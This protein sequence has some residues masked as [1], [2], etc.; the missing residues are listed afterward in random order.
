MANPVKATIGSEPY[1]TTIRVCND[2][3]HTITADEPEKFNGKDS[4][5][6]PFDL[7]LS[8]LVACK[9]ITVR[10]YADRKGWPVEKIDATATIVEWDGRAASK[11]E[12]DMDF[13]GDLT[14]EQKQRLLTIAEQCPVQKTLQA[15]L[16]VETMLAV[17]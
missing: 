12:V 5:P 8:S 6:A 1:C 7:L 9:V 15:G 11:I 10:M 3:A 4:G 14:D 13:E 2:T 17:S 16:T